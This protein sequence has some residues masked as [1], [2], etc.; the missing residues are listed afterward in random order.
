MEL[1]QLRL[2]GESRKSVLAKALY[3]RKYCLVLAPKAR[4]PPMRTSD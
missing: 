3:A 2:V 1:E 4:T